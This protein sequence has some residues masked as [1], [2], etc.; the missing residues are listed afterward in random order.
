MAFARPLRQRPQYQAVAQAH[1][2]D[3]KA[4][5]SPRF[6]CGRGNECARRAKP[7]PPSLC[8][9]SE[10]GHSIS[11]TPLPCSKIKLLPKST[12]SVVIE[13]NCSSPAIL[14]PLTRQGK[15]QGTANCP[16]F[17]THTPLG[18]KKKPPVGGDINAMPLEL[19]AKLKRA[20]AKQIG[21]ARRAARSHH[22]GGLWIF[23]DR[24]GQSCFLEQK[25]DW[26][27]RMLKAAL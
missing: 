14:S 3:H 18:A 5:A 2:V 15:C 8:I 6:R 24:D 23:G 20:L 4:R 11:K 7:I 10:F 12:T 17:T 25:T 16:A 9:E 19:G 27:G 1:G 13:N 21:I 26:L 22:K